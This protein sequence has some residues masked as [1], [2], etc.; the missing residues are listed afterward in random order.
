MP[1][2]QFVQDCTLLDKGLRNYWG[3]NTIGFFAPHNEYAA[4]GAARP[5]GAGVQGRWCARCTPPASRSSSTW[6]TTT[7]PRATTSARRCRSAASTT[8]RTTASSTTTSEYYMDYTGTGNSLNVRHPHSLQLIMDSLRYWVTEMHVDGF[9]F[10]L[11]ATLAREFYE[12]DRLSTFFELVQQDPVVS[13]GEADRRAVGRRP[14]R[15]PGRQLPAA[16]DGVERQVPRHRP[17]LLARR[18]VDAR[19]V[20][21]RGSPARPTSTRTPAAARSRRINFVTAHDGFTLR[22]LVSYNEKHNEANGEDG[23]DGEIAQPLVELRRRGRRPT[24]RRCSRCARGSSA[25]SSATLLLC[26]GV[27]MI[28][29]GDE[30]GRTQHGN[31]NT[32][33]RTPSS[34]GC[35]GTSADQPLI[36]FTAALVAAA[37]GAPDVPP[38]AASSTAGR[39][40]RGEGEPLPDIVWLQPDGTRDGAR[41]TGTA[42][43]G[44][45]DRRVPERQRHPR[46]R[47]PRRARSPTTTSC[48]LQRRT[49]R[50]VDFTLPP[51]GVRASSWDVVVDTGGAT[52]IDGAATAG[53][54]ARVER[55]SLVV[56]RAHTERRGRARPL[57]RRVAR[58]LATA[59]RPAPSTH[60]VPAE[61]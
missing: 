23:N 59:P 46:P 12:V 17:R 4:A 58:R 43:F 19:R 11:A 15:L 36:E 10:D 60:D 18:A 39:S 1:V 22:D 29:H 56:L 53:A 13:P 27:P 31:N 6:S 51:D 33:A 52:R 30:L 2:H 26:Q 28:L 54:T 42:G 7:P 20:R 40:T 32:Y 50:P 34:P 3:Y 35:T 24:T 14:R 49:T 57:G 5:A 9:R 41:A 55:T 21:R 45:V 44:T 37:H 47:R 48:S 38:R 61:R 16:V 25:T 8:P